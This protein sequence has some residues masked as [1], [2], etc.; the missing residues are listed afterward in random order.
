ME[1]VDEDEEQAVQWGWRWR[2]GGDGSANVGDGPLHPGLPAGGDAEDRSRELQSTGPL[3]S[4]STFVLSLPQGAGNE[5][6]LALAQSSMQPSASS[7][8]N[9]MAAMETAMSGESAASAMGLGKRV[10]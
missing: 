7:G 2:N 3:V 8:S 1:E 5:E 10:D 4:S 6:V 9:M